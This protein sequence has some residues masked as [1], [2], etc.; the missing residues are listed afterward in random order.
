MNLLTTMIM[1]TL[2]H[3]SV[4]AS[5]E[6]IRLCRCGEELWAK[7]RFRFYL[8]LDGLLWCPKG[9]KGPSK[10]MLKDGYPTKI[11]PFLK[12]V[13][14]VLQ[15]HGIKRRMFRDCPRKKDHPIGC[16]LIL[17]T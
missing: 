14:L 2:R 9:I 17:S 6:Y 7:S 4:S 16:A 12:N 5:I 3:C 15:L 13:S 8:D 11:A 1:V 10:S